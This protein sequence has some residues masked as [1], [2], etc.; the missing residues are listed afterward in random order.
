[1]QPGSTSRVSLE[2]RA[3][4][5]ARFECPSLRRPMMSQTQYGEGG[6][7]AGVIIITPVRKH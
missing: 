4:R 2:V 6:C 5:P 7:G 3:R 1:M